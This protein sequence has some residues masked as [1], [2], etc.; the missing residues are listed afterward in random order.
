M[1]D[2]YKRVLVGQYEIPDED[3]MG[4][5]VIYDKYKF[6]IDSIR[7]RRIEQITMTILSEEALEILETEEQEKETEE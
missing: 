7:D 4:K 1:I 3:D 5:E 2:T 6:R